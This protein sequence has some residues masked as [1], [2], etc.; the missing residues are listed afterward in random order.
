M[1]KEIPLT[2]GKIALVD[3]A[4]FDELNQFKW[5]ASRNKKNWYA[6]RSTKINGKSVQIR[7]HDVLLNPPEGKL[8]DHKDGNGLNNQ[9]DNL[10]ICT[11]AENNH[12][13][14]TQCRVKTSK[15]KGVSWRKDH[16]SWC[17][18]LGVNCK[19]LFLG[20][21]QVEIDAAKA[22]DA[23]ARFHF[24]EFARTNF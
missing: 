3:D 22:Y 19:N 9:R 11:F 6:L 13:T 2:Q 14:R 4:D 10:R 17:A 1:V 15:F 8:P 7:M 20:Y 18:V 21:F 24:G 12:N 23:A 16:L 5:F